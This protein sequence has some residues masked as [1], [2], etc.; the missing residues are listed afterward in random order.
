MAYSHA[1]PT[2]APE[3][4]LSM[5]ITLKAPAAPESALGQFW[6]R[7][8]EEIP[9]CTCGPCARVAVE[10]DPYFPYLDDFNRCQDHR[11]PYP[12][13]DAGSLS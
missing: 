9:T 10:V 7:Y 2:E 5:Q 6:R 3:A 4:E 13:G 8:F 12:Q 1:R 11:R